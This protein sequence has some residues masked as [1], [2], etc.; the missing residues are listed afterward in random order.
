M[1]TMTKKHGM[2]D[3]PHSEGAPTTRSAKDKERGNQAAA[4]KLERFAHPSQTTPYS[5]IKGESITVSRVIGRQEEP[6]VGSF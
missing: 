6:R 2:E 1:F 4:A 5:P 3:L